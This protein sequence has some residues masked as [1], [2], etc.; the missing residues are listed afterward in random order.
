[1]KRLG[2][3]LRRDIRMLFHVRHYHSFTDGQFVTRRRPPVF[4]REVLSLESDGSY[5]D[6]YTI[7]LMRQLS[8]TIAYASAVPSRAYSPRQRT[9]A[10]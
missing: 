10:S 4:M 8:Q 9:S 5:A 2:D 7:R 3:Y 6:T 1:M